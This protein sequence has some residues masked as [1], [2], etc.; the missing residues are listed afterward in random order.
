MNDQ[1][2]KKPRVRGGKIQKAKGQTI[3]RD[4]IR[5]SRCD[6]RSFISYKLDKGDGQ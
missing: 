6:S 5:G 4:W 1:P 3:K 2:T